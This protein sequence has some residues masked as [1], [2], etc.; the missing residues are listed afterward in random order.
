[1]KNHTSNSLVKS[2]LTTDTLKVLCS[3]LEMFVVLKIR[4]NI[5]T[6]LFRFKELKCFLSIGCEI[7]I[8]A[9]FTVSVTNQISLLTIK[10]QAK[11]E[12]N[13]YKAMSKKILYEQSEN[14]L[15]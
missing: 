11:V 12:A 13:H 15:G 10:R 4:L 3:P 2:V 5:N 1:M 7:V 9:A 8:G 6:A 14:L